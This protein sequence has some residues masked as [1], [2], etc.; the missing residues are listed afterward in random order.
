[1]T[2]MKEALSKM[3]EQKKRSNLTKSERQVKELWEAGIAPDK[4]HS[5]DA[6]RHHKVAHQKSGK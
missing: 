5:Q 2:A 4:T 3:S 6:D 1:M